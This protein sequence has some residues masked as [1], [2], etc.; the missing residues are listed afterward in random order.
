MTADICVSAPEMAKRR[1]CA[2]GGAVSRSDRGSQH[3]GARLAAWASANDVRLSVGRTGCCRDNAVAE[4][5][6]TSLKKEA[7]HRRA[8]ETREAARLA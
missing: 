4:S 8:S 2:A 6:W 1:G 7:C 3:T 5:L